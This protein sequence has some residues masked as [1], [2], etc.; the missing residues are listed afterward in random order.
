MKQFA[1]GFIAC[2][3]L[4]F[5]AV[6]TDLITIKPATPK[7]TVC[8]WDLNDNE[9]KEKLL[10]YATKGYIVKS[11]SGDRYRFIVMEKY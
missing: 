3:F 10:D 7:F 8:F 4:S 11:V 1:L 9:A 5:T 2:L 6:K